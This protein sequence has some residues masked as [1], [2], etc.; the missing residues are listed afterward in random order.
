MTD[1]ITLDYLAERTMKAARRAKQAT[2][3]PGFNP[4][5]PCQEFDKQLVE[6]EQIV[7][8][9][10]RVACL[11]ASDAETLEETAA[12][13]KKVTSLCDEALSHLHGLA[14]NDCQASAQPMSYDKIL[15]WRHAAHER[16]QLHS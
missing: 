6:T 16:W 5:E 8:T 3:Q 11:L 12:I 7:E 4:N 13:W 14:A 10:F 2:R 1:G 15:D 9:A